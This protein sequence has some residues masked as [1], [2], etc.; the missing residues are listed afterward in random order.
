MVALIY[1]W[2][3]IFTR[4]DKGPKFGEAV[5]TRALFQ[6]ALAR[7]TKPANQMRLS[8]SACMPKPR[9]PPILL[10]RIGE[11]LNL[12]VKPAEHLQARCRWGAMLRKIFE[13]YGRFALQSNPQKGTLARIKYRI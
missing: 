4:K 9:R 10:G 7:K 3:G 11:W 13:D 5:T 12:F 1:K 2:R 6:Q 8:I